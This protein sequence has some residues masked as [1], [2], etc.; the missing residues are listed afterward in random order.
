MIKQTRISFYLFILKAKKY[1]TNLMHPQQLRHW[2][3]RLYIMYFN[4]LCQPTKIPKR[5]GH[6]KQFQNRKFWGQIKDTKKSEDMHLKIIINNWM[7]RKV[8]PGLYIY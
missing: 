4:L 1:L 8:G 7:G 6:I 2:S 5:K 3:C